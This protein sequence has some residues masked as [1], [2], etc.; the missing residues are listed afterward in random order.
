MIRFLLFT[1]PLLI[2]HP[3]V[4]DVIVVGNEKSQTSS[5]EDLEG[6]TKALESANH[7]LSVGRYSEYRSLREEWQMKASFISEWFFLDVQEYLL[8]GNRQGAIDL[9]S[10]HSFTGKAETDRLVQLAALH[11]VESPSN[12]W[13]YLAEASTKDPRNAD[14]HT[15]KANLLDSNDKHENAEKEFSHA[16]QKD[17]NNPYLKEQLA[18]FYI[19]NGRFLEATKVLERGL[20]NPSLSSLWIKAL[21]WSRMATPI[22][23]SKSS[24]PPED[25][26]APFVGYLNGLPPQMYWDAK[27]FGVLTDKET[28]LKTQQETFWL[29]LVAALRIDDISSVENLLN[30]NSFYKD[31]L[32]P[33]LE[34]SLKTVIAYRKGTHPV[35]D[36]LM[37]LSVD[38]TKESFIVTLAALSDVPPER[39]PALIP[40]ELHEILKSNE[41]FSIPFLAHGW[42]EAA[43]QL[44]SSSS[45]PETSPSWIALELTKALVENRG[46]EVAMTFASK[47]KSSPE[48]TLLMAETYLAL[49]NSKEAFNCLS[50]I[51]K[52]TDDIGEEATLLI[53]PIFLAQNNCSAVKESILNQPALANNISARELLARA[54]Y[55]EGDA[56]TACRLYTSLQEHSPEAKSFLAQKAFAEKDW[57][58]AYR[59]TSELIEI[60]PDSETLKENLKSIPMR[61]HIEVWNK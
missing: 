12:A 53:A 31:S 19:R 21:F 5:Y 56:E 16:I 61:M 44:H 2:A 58:R 46:G 49:D 24:R 13:E 52:K 3:V 34:K 17:P 1:L 37:Q 15:F 23:I 42:Y 30:N 7:L 20:N 40:V 60:Y 47:Q 35:S 18:D 39:L 59:L 14:L 33:Q 51:Y 10:A 11:V 4:S 38:S 8:S 27:A 45:I 28:Y 50:C 32:A 41:A 43:L 54:F 36:S 57:I 26:L 55:Q 48:L 6:E 29:Q 22:A 9:L 25:K